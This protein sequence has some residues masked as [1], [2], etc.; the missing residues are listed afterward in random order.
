MNPE[1]ALLRAVLGIH[2]INVA[3]LSNLDL[4]NLFRQL[5]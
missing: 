2:R 5:L 4:D 3:S 1:R